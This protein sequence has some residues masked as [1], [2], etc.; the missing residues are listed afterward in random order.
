MMAGFCNRG[1]PC[2]GLPDRKKP[3]HFA[4]LSY[5]HSHYPQETELAISRIEKLNKGKLVSTLN[6][7]PKD[8][9]SDLNKKWV[10]RLLLYRKNG[11]L[12]WLEGS[13]KA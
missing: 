2:I 1:K 6:K 12:D 9:M 5:L 11:I 4:L 13:V 10:L 3:K 8:I 7:I